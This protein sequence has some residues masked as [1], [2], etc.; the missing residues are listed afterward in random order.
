MRLLYA[1]GRTYAIEL[2]MLDNLPAWVDNLS[3]KGDIQLRG[4]AMRP[5]PPDPHCLIVED[6]V[7]VGMDLEDA[8]SQAGFAVRWVASPDSASA[9]LATDRPDV[10]VLDVVLRD[11]S[12]TAL[13][14]EL[15]RRGIPIVVHGGYAPSK[16]PDGL[17][18]VPWPAK[19]ADMA[20]PLA[21]ASAVLPPGSRSAPAVTA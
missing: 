15:R 18:G 21:A 19:P 2:K 8:L 9:L 14:C 3:S 12:C 1:I 7:L 17:A 20:T 6:E 4:V 16:V 11:R 13:A 10:V 5:R